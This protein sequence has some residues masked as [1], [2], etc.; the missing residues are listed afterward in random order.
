[1]HWPDHAIDANSYPRCDARADY[2]MNPLGDEE[3][4][5]GF[6]QHPSAPPLI[7]WRVPVGCDYSGFFVEVLNFLIGLQSF[8]KRSNDV[9]YLWTWVNARKSFSGRWSLRKPI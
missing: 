5:Y 1:M 3:S 7:V 4:P 9:L 8:A 6:F 2:N